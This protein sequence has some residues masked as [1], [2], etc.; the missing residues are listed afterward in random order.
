MYLYCNFSLPRNSRRGSKQ[1]Q[2]A[3]NLAKQN[4]SH[5]HQIFKKIGNVSFT[6]YG[7]S[8]NLIEDSWL[9]PATQAGVL[10][11]KILKNYLYS[12]GKF[13]SFLQS[14]YF[15]ECPNLGQ[16]NSIIRNWRASLKN[17]ESRETIQLRMKQKG[18]I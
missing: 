16:F 2:V 1:S 7:T 18:N 13:N 11:A 12:L 15:D 8:Y 3:E 9:L 14:R 5:I 4:S 10:K 6:R 17:K